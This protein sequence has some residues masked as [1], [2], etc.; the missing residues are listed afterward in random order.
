MPFRFNLFSGSSVFGL[1][2]RGLRFRYNPQYGALL[3]PIFMQ[4]LPEELKLIVSRKYK[5]NWELDAVMEAVK[6]EVQARERCVIGTTTRPSPHAGTSEVKTEMKKMFQKTPIA[7]ASA[8]PSGN[9]K[10]L[11]CLFCKEEHRASECKNVTSVEDRKAILKKQGR[12]FVCLRRSGHI[13]QN[14]TSRI[15]CMECKG[16]HHLAVCEKDKVRLKKSTD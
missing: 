9:S 13:A 6:S 11:S 4:K 1:R 14:C 12:C 8:L 3:I 16:R 10:G 5:D 15:Q 2:F 7:I